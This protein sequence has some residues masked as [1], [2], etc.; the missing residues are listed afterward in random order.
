ML[1]INLNEFHKKVKKNS[2]SCL[3]SIYIVP[4][5]KYQSNN[6]TQY[7]MIQFAIFQQYPAKCTTY[8]LH[9]VVLPTYHTSYRIYNSSCCRPCICSRIAN[10]FTKSISFFFCLLLIFYQFFLQSFCLIHPRLY[11]YERLEILF[12]ACVCY[13][14]VE[15]FNIENFYQWFSLLSKFHPIRNKSLQVVVLL[16]FNLICKNGKFTVFFI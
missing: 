10:N 2:K 4:H 14:R 7:S 1:S 12:F 13:H 8:I 9:Y 5:L 16:N 15:M 3:I 6:W 11:R